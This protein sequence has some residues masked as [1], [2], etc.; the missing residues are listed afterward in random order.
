MLPRERRLTTEVFD[1]TIASGRL[2]HSPLITLTAAKA[3]SISEKKSRF[4]AVAPKKFFKTAVERNSVR[5]RLYSAMD[6]S[7]LDRVDANFNSAA[8]NCII[9]AKPALMKLTKQHITAAII[10]IFVKS[11]II[12]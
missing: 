11:S 10:D 7:F 12:K 5:R 9:I 3:G 6:T 8:F 2:F 1:Q 4:A